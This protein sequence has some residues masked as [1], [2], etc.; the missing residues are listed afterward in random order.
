MQNNTL[1]ANSLFDFP[2]VAVLEREETPEENFSEIKVSLTDENLEKY[3]S[4]NL[5]KYI[6]DVETL[7]LKQT[8]SVICKYVLTCGE[9]ADFLNIKNFG[10]MY[11]IGLAIQD[12]IQKK[13]NGQYYTPDDVALI[14]SKW[15]LNL[16]G[17]KVCD[18]ACGTGKLILT[19]L[20]LIGE[21]NARNLIQSG[22][23][24]LYDLDETA[25]EICKTSILIKYGLELEGNLHC[26]DGDFL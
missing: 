16:Q 20:D 7:G 23:L 26:I 5:E 1:Y 12:K 10:E 25:L 18:V 19:Y 15:L 3:K 24:Y 22:N 14:M 6:N 21:K 8:W 2:Y 17:E 13:N 11:E 4:Y 9:N